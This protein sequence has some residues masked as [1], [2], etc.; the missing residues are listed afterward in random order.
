MRD[1]LLRVVS[2]F[3]WRSKR[4]WHVIYHGM[5]PTGVFQAHYGFSTDAIHWHVSPRQAYS[6]E[7]SYTDAPPEL[8]AR[9]ERPQL[10]FG[11]DSEGAAGGGEPSVLYNGVCAATTAEE[12]YACLELKSTTPVMTWTLARP[13]WSKSDDDDAAARRTAATSTVAGTGAAAQPPRS[14]MSESCNLNGEATNGGGCKCLAAWRGPTCGELALLPA[15]PKAGL[16]AQSSLS[17]WGGAVEFDSE[18][19][20]YVMFG[21]ELVGG[22]GIN[23]CV[24]ILFQGCFSL[25]NLTSHYQSQ[26]FVFFN[27]SKAFSRLTEHGA[28]LPAREGAGGRRI[29]ELCGPPHQI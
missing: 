28:A 2:P 12:I 6:Y 18:S 13:L 4:G 27:H 5:C 11:S 19:K 15:F 17:S 24:A 8:F 10:G 9:V 29:R 3:M 20:R 26:G 22:C 25:S 1:L 7:V 16:H 23:S 21:N 14:V